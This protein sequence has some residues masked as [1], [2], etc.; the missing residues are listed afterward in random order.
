[1]NGQLTPIPA[2]VSLVE[3]RSNSEMYPR[4][5]R[6]ARPFALRD[7]AV[8]ISKALLY[9]G[10]DAEAEKVSFIASSLYDELMA[11]E[12]GLGLQYI[13]MEEISRVVRRASLDKD[14]FG[15]SVATLYSAICTFAKGE[16]DAAQ[17]EADNNK[18]EADKALV[19][20][21]YGNAIDRLAEKFTSTHKIK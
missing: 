12:Q 9:R 5:C 8:I 16:G 19:Q 21:H 20:E 10:Q 3:I 18:K 2:P 17:R 14:T 1:M 4:L 13:T 6:I 11:D 15:I 7:L